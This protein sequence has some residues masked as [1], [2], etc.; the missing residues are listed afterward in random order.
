MYKYRYAYCIFFNIFK[1]KKKKGNLILLIK[2]I[3]TIKLYTDYLYK[4]VLEYMFL[5]VYI[6]FLL[7]FLINYLYK[8]SENFWSLETL[9][10]LSQFYKPHYNL[11]SL[12]R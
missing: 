8:V 11:K 4:L 10:S 3:I 6:L 9:K 5:N 2:Q 7:K 12:Q 1:K